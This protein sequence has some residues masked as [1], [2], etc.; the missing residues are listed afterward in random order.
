MGMHVL[1]W[2]RWWKTICQTQ[3]PLHIA[4]VSHFSCFFFLFLQ[5]SIASF[6]LWKG[7]SR[8]SMI[9]RSRS[10]QYEKKQPA[11]GDLKYTFSENH[12]NSVDVFS[13]C[14]RRYQKR[15]V[16]MNMADSIKVNLS[17]TIKSY[18]LVGKK[19]RV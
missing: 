2:I 16:V 13:Q 8:V 7:I 17:S 19:Y 15:Q 9:Q 4:V 18:Q 11:R 3:C 10:K 14:W 6:R 12:R 1:Q 5:S